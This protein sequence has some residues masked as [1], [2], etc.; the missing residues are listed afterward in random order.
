MRDGGRRCWPA[1][2]C[3]SPRIYRSIIY[4]LYVDNLRLRICSIQRRD[5]QPMEK[6]VFQERLQFTNP[7]GMQGLVRP[8]RTRTTILDSSCTQKLAT[9]S[10][11]P[12]YDRFSLKISWMASNEV[13]EHQW[14]SCTYR[15]QS[16][17]PKNIK[18]RYTGR[19]TPYAVLRCVAIYW[20]A[21]LS[22][23]VV[24]IKSIYMPYCP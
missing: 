5:G 18:S 2:V 15:V 17:P 13:R 1:R 9:L 20:W 6:P 21:S 19:K 24:Q 23:M 7:G 11:A 14:H 12:P 3:G 4:Y 22:N 10:T 16:I 8:D